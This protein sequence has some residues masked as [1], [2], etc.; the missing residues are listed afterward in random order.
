MSPVGVVIGQHLAKGGEDDSATAV[1]RDYQEELMDP[2]QT[3][4]MSA[5]AARCP[6][7]RCV[8]NVS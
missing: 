4:L 3:A 2:V 6:T 5:A 8:Q 1:G 7:F